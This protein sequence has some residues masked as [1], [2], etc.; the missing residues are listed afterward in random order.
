[1][2]GGGDHAGRE[3]TFYVDDKLVHVYHDG[4]HQFQSDLKHQKSGKYF[5]QKGQ[6]EMDLP[7]VQFLDHLHND[8]NQKAHGR[9]KNAII[10]SPS[11]TWTRSCSKYDNP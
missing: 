11:D 10:S 6:R 7:R 9:V 8:Q 5:M 3:D 1:M 4:L 2:P